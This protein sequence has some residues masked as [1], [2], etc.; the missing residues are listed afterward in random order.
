MKILNHIIAVLLF[1]P[2]TISFTICMLFEI[3]FH[4]ANGLHPNN[5][6]KIDLNDMS[7]I[8]IP[9]NR[10]VLTFF[11]KILIIII[12]AFTHFFKRMKE[13]FEYD[14]MT[15]EIEDHGNKIP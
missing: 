13:I 11:L 10:F 9:K 7:S 6:S 5:F 15:K 2:V 8:Y 12:E 1:L 4:V 14:F 3:V